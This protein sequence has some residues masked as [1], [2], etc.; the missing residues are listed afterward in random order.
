[1]RY[2]DRKAI[3]LFML[4]YMIGTLV[5]FLFLGFIIVASTLTYS[6][7]SSFALYA[8]LCFT[9]GIIVLVGFSYLWA[10][11]T[12]NNYKFEL[13]ED[14]FKKEQGVIFKRYVSIPYDRIQN[15]DI[16]RGIL[17]RLLGLSDLQ[18]QTAGF[19]FTGQYGAATEGRL[20]GLSRQ[21]AEQLRDELIARAKQ[22]KA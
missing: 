11:L 19:S 13:S 21:D 1:M 12:Y 3:L 16:Y 4:N 20:P 2:L 7:D 5:T 17:A 22:R 14:S 6:R 8:L 9:V 10:V 15:V 18:I